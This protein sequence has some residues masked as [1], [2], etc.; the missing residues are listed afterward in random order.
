MKH[1]QGEH[2]VTHRPYGARWCSLTLTAPAIAPAVQ[3]IEVG[4]EGG[5][6]CVASSAAKLNEE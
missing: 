3:R 6:E 5:D 4:V 2:I 1:T